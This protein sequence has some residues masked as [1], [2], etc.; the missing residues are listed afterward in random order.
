MVFDLANYFIN[1]IC[2]GIL[3]YYPG[4]KYLILFEGILSSHSVID[5]LLSKSETTCTATSYNIFVPNGKYPKWRCIWPQLCSFISTPP[6][7][8]SKSCLCQY[9]RLKPATG[10]EKIENGVGKKRTVVIYRYL[11]DSGWLLHPHKDR[12]PEK[13]GGGGISQMEWH[14][15]PT[16]FSFTLFF[17]I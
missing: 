12:D 2:G 9:P 1:L 6:W 7:H 8:Y 4:V 11:W 5:I 14:F 17:L 15:S 10:D 3:F 16:P 13:N